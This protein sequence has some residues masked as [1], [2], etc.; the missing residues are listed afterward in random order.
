MKKSKQSR[1]WLRIKNN[2]FLFSK[3]TRSKSNW[4]IIT[5]MERN[6]I[7]TTQTL[8]TYSDL[9]C[10]L[11]CSFQGA[12]QAEVFRQNVRAIHN[13][14][15]KTKES[16][17]SK[18]PKFFLRALTKSRNNK[19]DSSQV[20]ISLHAEQILAEDISFSDRRQRVLSSSETPI[21]GFEALKLWNARSG[22]LG[23]LSIRQEYSSSSCLLS[24]GHGDQRTTRP[25]FSQFQSLEILDEF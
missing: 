3:V 18:S 10:G 23:S 12:S 2:G 22:F 25:T 5:W 24:C 1:G 21:W 13:H 11:L 7:L 8:C 16:K 17:F 4:E 9:H 19:T 15:S 20:S 14:R 6:L